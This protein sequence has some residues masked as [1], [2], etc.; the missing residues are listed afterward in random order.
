MTASL[1]A[2][3]FGLKARSAAPE[4]LD[5]VAALLDAWDVAQLGDPDPNLGR[6]RGD[7]VAPW[8]DPGRDAL[9]VEDAAGSMIA[10]VEFATR[11]NE[12]ADARTEGFVVSHPDAPCELTPWLVDALDDRSRKRLPRAGDRWLDMSEL[13][14]ATMREADARGYPLVRRFAHLRRSLVPAPVPDLGPLQGGA[15]IRPMRRPDD[16]RA[17]HDVLEEAFADHFGWVR[18]PFEPWAEEVF[19]APG[20][21]EDSLLL[22]EVGGQVVGACLEWRLEG[23]IAWIA[24]LGVL[25]VARRGGLGSA[26]LRRAFADLARAGY[27]HAQLNVDMGNETNAMGVYEAAGM[28][29]RRTWRVV[30]MPPVVGPGPLAEPTG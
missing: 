4:D 1:A 22:A 10:Y 23:E 19:E 8:F 28:H 30:Q 6:M 21:V 26:L 25:P 11:S 24:D 15:T 29:L 18:T 27:A 17:A 20:F 9:V 13:D 7:W 5:A 12:P 2:L 3:P 16:E 14:A